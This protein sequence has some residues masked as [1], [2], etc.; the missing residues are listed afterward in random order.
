MKARLS[1][2][3]AIP[4]IASTL[5]LLGLVVGA[6]YRVWLPRVR[7]LAERF[8]GPAP[9]A[10]A[11]GDDHEGHDHGHDHSG[12][13]E[14]TSIELSASGLRNIGFH[15]VTVELTEFTRS[16][17]IPAI[18]VERPGRSQIHVTAPLTGLIT[19]IY[20]IQGAA[21]ASGSPLFEIRLTHEELVGS[22]R[23]L[24]RTAE[25]LD[26]V[27][28]EIARL[29]S[30]SEGI[31]AGK[32]ILEQQY[33]RQKLESNLT[34]ERQSLLL[35]GLSEEQIRTV[36][37]DRELFQSLTVRA[38][39]HNDDSETCAEEH[40]FHVQELPVKLGQ[41]I[42]VGKVLCVLADHCELYVEGRAFEGD[43]TRLRE[44]AREAW[45]VSAS[46]LVG[47]RET[48]TVE[49]LKLLYL[50]DRIDA[51][52]RAFRFYLSLPNDILLEK[53][54]SGHQFI[55]W[56]FKPGQRM[57]VHIPIERW[58]EQIVLPVEA[59]VKEGAENYVYQQN[60]DHFDRVPVTV[61]YRDQKA[62]VVANDGSIFPG[63]VVAGRGAYQMH[64]ALKNKAGGGVD[65]HAGHSH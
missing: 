5:V 47:Q 12:H 16:L 42:E 10:Q 1:Q 39:E 25:S 56:R 32:R 62:V 21:I 28:R 4:W 48:E 17:T 36:L 27:N 26:V 30:L 45:D 24:I 19:K 50:S 57:E 58:D 52:T 55:E 18:V 34:A 43:A 7:A 38:P 64:L 15:P 51:E 60:G 3:R 53:T 22:Q 23:D 61:E 37:E 11:E 35:H 54:V 46:L 13:S 59:I 14:D 29:E 40:L 31:V 2:R 9:T 49:G 65:P 44:A 41:Q 8:N 33:E 20:P 63:D 6:T